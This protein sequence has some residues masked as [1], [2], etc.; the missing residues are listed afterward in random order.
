L[1]FNIQPT[2]IRAKHKS[3][4]KELKPQASFQVTSVTLEEGWGKK[5]TLK[6]LARLKSERENFATVS[7]AVQSAQT[8]NNH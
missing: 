3:S 7:K 5:V 1:I 4:N 8:K 6:E 2:P